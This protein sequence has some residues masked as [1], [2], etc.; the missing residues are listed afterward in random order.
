MELGSSAHRTDSLPLA[1][2][3]GLAHRPRHPGRQQFDSLGNLGEWLAADVDLSEVAHVAKHFVLGQDLLDYL[4]RAAEQ[5]HSLG[6]GHLFKGGVRKLLPPMSPHGLIEVA[7]IGGQEVLPRCLR[8][9][10]DVHMREGRHPCVAGVEAEALPGLPIERHGL[11]VTWQIA[12]KHW[13]R[14]G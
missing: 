5:Q 2:S 3:H 13:Q 4:F 7:R 11:S 10:R 12:A 14:K 9:L 8:R 6:S 1:R